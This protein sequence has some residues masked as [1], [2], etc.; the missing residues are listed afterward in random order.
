MARRSKNVDVLH[1]VRRALRILRRVEVSMLADER[2]Q[3]KRAAKAAEKFLDDREAHIAALHEER[4]RAAEQA[5]AQ[6]TGGIP[7]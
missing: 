6:R 5:E 1:E 2:A 7:L 4:D 3:K